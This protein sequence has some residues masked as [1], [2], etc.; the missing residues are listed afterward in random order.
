M[1]KLIEVPDIL[2]RGQKVYTLEV[3]PDNSPEP[4]PTQPTA[5]VPTVANMVQSYK[6]L[7]K[8]KK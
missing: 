8:G 3:S 1:P 6:R 2:Y 7:N 5:P 4:T